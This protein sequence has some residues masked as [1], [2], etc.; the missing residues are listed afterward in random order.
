MNKLIT[1]LFIFFFASQNGKAQE[2][3]QTI[4]G[5]VINSET[6]EPLTFATISVKNSQPA[7]GGV[8]NENGEFKIEHIPM[9]R[10]N[11][12]ASHTG[13]APLI[14]SEVIVTSAKEIQLT[15]RLTPLSSAM[16][17]II[18]VPKTNKQKPI[19]STA[20]VSTRMLS[21]EEASRYAG[22]FD[23]PARLASSFA[24]VAGGEGES[25]AIV[26]RGN[27][28]KSLQWKIEGVEIPNPNHFAN[29]GSFGGGGLTALS[30]NLLANSD[31]MTGAFPAEYNNALG[32]IFDMR[33]RNGN[34]NVFE[35]SIEVGLL[36]IDLTSEGPLT[37]NQNTSKNASYL[38]NYRYST[39]ALLSPLMPDDA[40]GTQYQDLSFK[41]NLPT[42]KSGTFSLWGIGLIDE[43]GAQPETNP[44][45]RKYYQDIEKQDVKQYMGSIGLNHKYFF[46]NA[47]WLN[48][49]LA[50]SAEGIN[51]ITDRLNNENHLYP[52]NRIK[53][54]RYNLT[55]TSSYNRKIS[56]KVS[57]RSGIT[58]NGLGY[59]INIKQTSAN[60]TLGSVANGN[61]LTSLI[62]AFTNFTLSGRKLRWNLGLSTQL[63]TLNNSYTIEPRLG[64]SYPIN[65]RNTLSFGYGLHSRLEPL[66]I[67][68]ANT[69]NSISPE[70]NKELGFTRAN[71]FVLGYDWSITQ[72]LHLK[73]EPY[74]QALFDV[75]I[76]ENSNE[77]LLNL[78]ADWFIT[79]AYHNTGK[80]RN[81]GL[82][83][84][85]EQYMN[86]GFYFLIT[87]SLFN[88]EYK[89]ENSDWFNTRYNKNYLFNALA[90]KEFK[91]GSNQQNSFGV[92]LRIS[93]Q[94]GDRFSKIDDAASSAEQD[95]VYNETTPFT[96]QTTPS[97]VLHTTIT[98]TWNRKK[99]TQ[100]L[101]LKIL[102]VTN[103]ESFLGHR[104]NLQ[105]GNVDEYREALMLPNL[106]YKISF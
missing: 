76:A 85:L 10:V 50:L 5:K 70:A 17:E 57:N 45:N 30:S 74:F 49:T 33:M 24:G 59:D 18:I 91:T 3:T 35:N 34:N 89:T 87:G 94:G 82:D 29:L 1:V 67:Y 42:A 97:S 41:I 21:V 32:G 58:Y 22:G 20:T 14:V 99:I 106:S 61:G 88:S 38:V 84:T 28:P 69:V 39:L 90:G 96:Q 53:S 104:Y 101:S 66:Q 23:D 47:A 102:N 26:V 52:E 62:A 16:D 103:Y 75:P 31:F 51:A 40:E 81:Y 77:S 79:T 64:I 25:N 95:V 13:F 93:V 15:I 63:F 19:N 2:L 65:D 4:S 37:K 60:D 8:T 7:I 80:G 9:G 11:V 36:G 44:D 48:S 56:N 55:F 72:K 73:I 27:A 98:Y 54:N 68:F 92:N 78:D 71:H 105:T 43:S 83:V 86:H 6:D 46:K 12:E 100:K